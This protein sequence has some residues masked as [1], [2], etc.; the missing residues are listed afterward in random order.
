MFNNVKRFDSTQSEVWKYVFDKEDAVAEAVLYRYESF[1]KR[2]V[3]CI[4]TQS[5]CPVGCSFCGTGKK[6]VRNLTWEEIVYQ[7]KHALKDMGA[8]AYVNTC[9]KFQIMFM[10]MG[11]PMLNWSDLAQA[12]DWLNFT[13]PKAQ[14]L[15]STVGVRDKRVF[16]DMIRIS[17][18]IDKVGLQFSIHK[19]FDGER[20]ELIPFRNKLTLREIRDHGMLWNKE[21]G[22]PVF[23]NYCVDGTNNGTVDSDR[24]M[25]LFSPAVFNFTF[26]VVCS[27]D[28]TMKDAGFRHMATIQEFQ[29]RFIDAGYNTRIFDPAGQDDIGGG[30]GQLWYVQRWLQENGVGVK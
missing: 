8:D 18:A 27:A 3:L 13:Y 6:F 2:I 19:A 17:K 24:L 7:A 20:N 23:L 29:Q 26:S 1:A 15:I 11:E 5:G 16:E 30:C 4:S 12:I 28:E 10:S 21:V 22:R 14:L 25:D 9:E